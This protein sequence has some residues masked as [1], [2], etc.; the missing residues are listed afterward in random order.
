MNDQNPNPLERIIEQQRVIHDQQRVVEQRIQKEANAR[1]LHEFRTQVEKLNRLLVLDLPTGTLYWTD[2][3]V[4]DL[5]YRQLD[6][7]PYLATEIAHE[8]NGIRVAVR[9]VQKDGHRFLTIRTPAAI[10]Q[11]EIYLETDDDLNTTRTNTFDLLLD[12]LKRDHENSMQRRIEDELTMKQRRAAGDIMALTVEWMDEHYGP[13]VRECERYAL[14]WTEKRWKPWAY[15]TIRYTNNFSMTDKPVLGTATVLSH[16]DKLH[17]QPIFQAVN[18]DGSVYELVIG[19]FL[20][21]VE[22]RYSQP[23]TIYSPLDYHRSVVVGPYWI[24]IPPICPE[25]ITK[26]ITD[27]LPMTPSR[28]WFTFV[29]AYFPMPGTQQKAWSDSGLT[30]EKMLLM[31]EDAFFQSY[32]HLL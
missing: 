4:G 25:E 7:I 30:P 10:G 20:D 6:H 16:M 21:G 13:Y 32:R 14:H 1:T 23:A 2:S 12:V 27:S 28:T 15:Q 11:V 24:N 18:Q 22:T 19:A 9:F 31:G 5:Y 29:C 3:I 17:D 26:Q 8:V